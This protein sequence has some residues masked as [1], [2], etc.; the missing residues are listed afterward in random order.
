MVRLLINIEVIVRIFNIINGNHNILF[1][2]I[3]FIRDILY[4]L[5]KL[6]SI[7]IISAYIRTSQFYIGLIMDYVNYEQDVCIEDSQ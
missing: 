5:L 4:R 3:L 6:Q 7:Y 1:S 2:K